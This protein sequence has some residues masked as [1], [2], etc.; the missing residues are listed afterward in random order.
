M[1]RIAS[2][3]Q[4]NTQE[5]FHVKGVR[6]SMDGFDGPPELSYVKSVLVPIKQWADKQLRDYHL[7]F[8]DV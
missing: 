8:A 5:R 4:R 1:K 7:Q 3:S 6:A 2:D